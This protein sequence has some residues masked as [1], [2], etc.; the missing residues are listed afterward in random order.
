VSTLIL[1]S[2]STGERNAMSD[3][4]TTIFGY[5]GGEIAFSE[6]G[7]RGDHATF[8]VGS[9]PRLYDKNN[10]GWRDGETVWTT[11]SCW[12]A[13]AGNVKSSVHIGDPVIVIGKRRVNTWTDESGDKREREFVDAITVCHDLA[14]GTSVFRK[15]PRLLERAEDPDQLSRMLDAAEQSTV[16]SEENEVASGGD[17]AA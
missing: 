12:R 15:T 2:V 10:G 16:G 6:G 8:R 4:Q 1:R 11:V 9:T 13:L 14:R 17:V 3:V 5:V 7:A